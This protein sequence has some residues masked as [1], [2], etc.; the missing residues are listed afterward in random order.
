M[1]FLRQTFFAAFLGFGLAL[2]VSAQRQP[3]DRKKPPKENAE[4]KPE[5]KKPPKGNDNPNN[6]RG[7]DNRPRKP[8]TFFL[9]SE[10]RIEISS[11]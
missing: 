10:N 11:T 4:I 3:D 7:N 8:Q 9:I 5:E 6:N 2:S 1:K